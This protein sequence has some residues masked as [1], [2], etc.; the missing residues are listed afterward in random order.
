M[1]ATANNPSML[2]TI[3]LELPTD[4]DW[5][6]AD[7]RPAPLAGTACALVFI[8]AGSV[9]SQQRLHELLDLQKRHRDR[10]RVLAVHV[11]RFDFERNPD[12]VRDQ[13]AVVGLRIPVAL[14]PQWALWRQLG[15]EAWPTTLLVSHTGQIAERLVG[16]GSLQPLQAAVDA[17]CAN[18]PVVEIEPEGRKRTDTALLY[19]S[20]VAVL[21][22]YI[23]V[24]DTGH[25]RILE[26]DQAGRILRQFGTGAG[27]LVDGPADL[28][29]FRRP[30]EVSVQRGALYVADAGNHAVR[31]IDL[32][33]GDVVTLCGNGR[34]G[35]PNPG[36]VANA[37]DVMLDAPRSV[38]LLG[39][40]LYIACAGDNRI[41]SYDLGTRMIRAE[42]G[43]GALTIRDGNG[44]FAAFAQPVS[45]AA[46]HHTLYVCD[47]A[48]SAI[49]TFN[50]RSGQV[51]TLVGSDPWTFGNH[52]GNRSEAQLQAPQAIA[53]D[54]DSPQLWIADAGNGT[55]R[56]LRLG[57][58]E[59]K[60][61]PLP[62]PLQA[63]CALAA[64]EGTLWIA[65]TDAHAILRLDRHSGQMRR[66]PIGE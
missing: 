42:A 59:M 31:R 56:T 45:L 11:P 6:N 58:G 54:P 10:L 15:I 63:P 18:A 26:C 55:L 20:G 28:A 19:P 65:D 23:Y 1:S 30:Q 12:H 40:E 38:A 13:L 49:R 62:E 21:G 35:S 43:S 9:W 17:L 51:T 33:S 14:D 4:L 39:G 48:A 53:L 22:S 57:G 61:V 29:S 66:L 8:N 34:P 25:H 60:T 32:R 41:W 52:D 3:P 2:D 44:S 5:L 64:A 46:A 37:T 7:V 24:A 50:A 16:A 36:P 47:E 27:E